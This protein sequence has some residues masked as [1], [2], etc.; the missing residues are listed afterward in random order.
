LFRYVAHQKQSNKYYNEMQGTNQYY[1]NLATEDAQA[2]GGARR[3]LTRNTNF[4][5][6]DCDVC[7]QMNCFYSETVAA[8]EAEAAGA[9]AAP[10]A[11]P[12]SETITNWVNEL[13]QCQATGSLFLNYF[14]L[15]AGFMCNEDGSGVD[16]ALFLDE[17]C[18]VYNANIGYNTIASD[19]NRAVMYAATDMITYP[20]L[21]RINCNGQYTY[22]S[23]DDYREQVSMYGYYKN[24]EQNAEGELSAY[25]S[26]IY[27]GGEAG[28]AIALNDCDADGE[29]DERAE[30]DEEVTMYYDESNS[31]LYSLSAEDAQDTEA[32]CKVIRN[33]QGE[34]EPVYR[35][36]GSGQIFNYG[37]GPTKKAFYDTSSIQEYLRAHQLDKMGASLITAIVAAVAVAMTALG[38]ILYSCCS[39]SS[40][41]NKYDEQRNVRAEHRKE[42][43]SKRERLVEEPE[44]DTGVLM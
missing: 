18:T 11:Q 24:N 36:A 5:V 27:E 1:E 9:T 32:V 39:P 10:A 44:P 17:D 4:E 20:F 25:C 40:V 19:Y 12:D 31:Y 23:M 6:I 16:I 15:Y 22:L 43:E 41:A 13:A 34:Y 30:G 29:K 37:T 35:W 26:S 3:E 14:A 7:T 21:H 2:D 38:C 28:K 8:A 33:M 42:I